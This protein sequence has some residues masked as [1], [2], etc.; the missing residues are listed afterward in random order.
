M[1]IRFAMLLQTTLHR[2]SQV[3]KDKILFILHPNSKSVSNYVR[4]LQFKSDGF[5][6][7]DLAGGFFSRKFFSVIFSIFLVTFNLIRLTFKA[8]NYNKVII[9]KPWSYPVCLFIKILFGERVYLDINDP[10]HLDCFWGGTSF[11][12]LSKTFKKNL[13][14]ES[15]EYLEYCSKEFNLT[16][17]LIEDYAQYEDFIDCEWSIREN[18][19]VWYGNP[20]LSLELLRYKNFFL[21]LNSVNIQ[22]YIVGASDL[23]ADVLQGGGVLLSRPR[24]DARQDFLHFLSHS[25]FIFIPFD[26]FNPLHTLRGNLKLKFAMGAGCAVFAQEIPMHLR[27]M[28]HG[29]NGFLF[30]NEDDLLTAFKEA[31]ILTD[32]ELISKNALKTV[33]D[34][35]DRNCY[36]NKYLMLGFK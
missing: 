24:F 30:K 11:N 25:K 10:L 21:Y 34:L 8:R 33:R 26:S 1:Y 19:V 22:I 16:G 9:V 29:L 35:G 27:L 23:V 5:D 7:L 15:V 3:V 13:I 4:A 12:F 32:F 31:L 17:T 2:N 14:F 36:R 6:F 28:L 18:R 20:E